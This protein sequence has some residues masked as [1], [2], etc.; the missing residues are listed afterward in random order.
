MAARTYWSAKDETTSTN[1]TTTPSTKL[2]LTIS[3]PPANKD[4]LIVAS[5]TLQISA[6]TRAHCDLYDGTSTLDEWSYNPKELTSPPD[7]IAG[8]LM[9][10]WQT[11]PS[12]SARSFSI[13]FWIQ[14]VTATCTIDKANIVAIQMESGD[15]YAE[16]TGTS[17]TTGTTLLDK[18][19]LTFDPGASIDYYLVSNSALNVGSSGTAV[20]RK[21]GF[22]ADGTDFDV[23]STASR[24]S[25]EWQSCFALRK[26]TLASGS[27]TIKTRYASDGTNTT[28][29]KN[30]RIAALKATN[31]EAHYY[32]SS[33]TNASTT[34]SGSYVDHATLTQT[35]GAGDHWIVGNF[36]TGGDSV[37]VSGQYQL[38][39]GATTL[40]HSDKESYSAS[41]TQ[42]WP[43]SYSTMR[44][45]AASSTTWKTQYKSETGSATTIYMSW[46][47]IGVLQLFGS[48]GG[49]GDG[50]AAGVATSS[51]VGASTAA[52]TAAA[53]GT[54]TA[55]GTPAVIASAS[56]TSTAAFAGL[57]VITADASAAGLA[58][59]SAVGES[60]AASV[61]S[62]AGAGTALGMAE[63]TADAVSASSGTSTAM[64]TG[65]ASAAAVAASAGVSTVAAIPTVV[66]SA[67]GTSTA[68]ATGSVVGGGEA[69]AAAAGTSTVAATGASLAESTASAAGTAVAVVYPAILAAAAGTSTAVAAG[70]AVIEAAAAAN[71]IAV[72]SFVGASTADAAASA[73]GTSVATGEGVAIGGGSPATAAGMATAEAIG[74]AVAEGSAEAAGSSNVV[75]FSTVTALAGGRTKRRRQEE[76]ALAEQRYADVQR[77]YEQL[78]GEGLK[79]RTE[80]HAEVAAVLDVVQP[81]LDIHQKNWPLAPSGA[82]SRTPPEVEWSEV[83][84][85]KATMRHLKWTLAALAARLR[86]IEEEEDEEAFLMAI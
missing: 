20:L 72:G 30:S 6:G 24:S 69:T 71:G 84:G 17:T 43:Q 54:G 18:D 47:S 73:A 70:N 49:A 74:A 33:D 62:S 26:V 21:W 61:A 5:C 85:D 2:T 31:F 60:T 80:A 75:A 28:T 83:A 46:S 50:S 32:G 25:G 15:Q 4:I 42:S 41:D 86:E 79:Q 8:S 19:T 68:A 58:A 37:T 40:V 77:A 45:L 82:Q 29:I 34:T 59:A 11:G 56:G 48:A 57:A 13:R 10:R 65:G 44:N 12:P 16:S 53:S 38:L 66:A 35:P 64:A 52:S 23:T 1:A 76:R 3:S 51:V 14:A 22:H 67:A 36:I 9:Y 27:R 39:E 63:S 81:Y 78:M 55:T 7:Q